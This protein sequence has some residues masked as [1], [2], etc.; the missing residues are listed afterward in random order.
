[1]TTTPAV[2]AKAMQIAREAI[3]SKKEFDGATHSAAD[4]RAGRWDGQHEVMDAY[5]G[6]IAALSAT[7]GEAEP[8]AFGWF[9]PY[10]PGIG[11]SLVDR[12]RKGA[13]KPFD[14]TQ[15]AFP[16]YASPPSAPA[17]VK[18]KD[19]LA[20]AKAAGEHGVRYRTNRALEAFLT[21]IRSSLQPDTQAAAASAPA[22]EG[23]A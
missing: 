20:V 22:Q 15:R 7:E 6:A 18:V 12:F 2:S 13:V 23:R 5:R 16:L 14:W 19:W 11:G 9:E 10:Y 4:V 8:V 1:M 17:G 3:A 21:D